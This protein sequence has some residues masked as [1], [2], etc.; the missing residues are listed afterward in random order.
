MTNDKGRVSPALHADPKGAV[1]RIGRVT[2]RLGISRS[3][4]YDWMNPASP[5]YDKDFPL[6]LRLSV[7]ADRGAIGWIESDICAFI[8]SRVTVSFR[9]EGLK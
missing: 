9:K 3:T 7:C 4:I 8:D 6:P 1:L 2:E 5:R